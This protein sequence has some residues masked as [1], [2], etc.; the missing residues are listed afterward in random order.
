VQA[1]LSHQLDWPYYAGLTAAGAQALG[2]LWRIRHQDLD[3]CF[4]AFRSNNLFGA[5][6]FLGIVAQAL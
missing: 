1:G 6:V 5:L 4:T 3:A 2:Q